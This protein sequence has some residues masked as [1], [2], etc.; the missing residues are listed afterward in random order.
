M[1][2]YT[3]STVLLVATV[4]SVGAC[5]DEVTAPGTPSLAPSLSVGSSVPAAAPWAEII[6]GVAGPGALYELRMPQNWNG[7]VVYYAHGFNDPDPVGAKDPTLFLPFKENIEATYKALGE[8]GYA[9]AASSFS[10][11]GFAI[12]DGVQRTHQ[13]RGLFTSRFGKADQSFLMGHSLGG[14]IVVEL[15]EKYPNQYDGAL[16]MCGMVGGSQLQIDYL[17][18]VRAAFDAIYPGVLRGDAVN[19]PADLT[20]EE[21]RAKAIQAMSTPPL[22]PVGALALTRL[23]P[24]PVDAPPG[25]VP[26]AIGGVLAALDFHV[27]G[28]ADVVA[29]TQGHNPFDNTATLYTGGFGPYNTQ[30]FA[31]QIKRFEATPDARNYLSHWY[32]PSGNLQIPVLTLHTMWDPAVPTSHER[33]LAAVVAAAGQSAFLRQNTGAFP[34]AFNHCGFGTAEI[35]RNFDQ[36]AS[37]VRSLPGN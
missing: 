10:E 16:A 5:A 24:T 33:K 26:A 19:I 2:R 3:R 17:G 1:I 11:N 9:I 23:L 20:R 14:A 35:V 29:H 31:D 36:L 37:W 4:I 22:G 21:V 27:R 15:A 34:N 7:D 30:F 25:S 32:E 8:K 28:G 18:N 6:N 12:K 13:L